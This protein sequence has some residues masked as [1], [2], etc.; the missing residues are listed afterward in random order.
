MLTGYLPFT[1][2]DTFCNLYYHVEGEW[3]DMLLQE[4]ILIQFKDPQLVGSA[5]FSHLC[6]IPVKMLIFY[7]RITVLEKITCLCTF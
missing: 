6:Q 7:V 3:R 4:S 2:V 5:V 1:G